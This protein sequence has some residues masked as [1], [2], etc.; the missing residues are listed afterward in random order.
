MDRASTFGTAR[1]TRVVIQKAG[2]CTGLCG[3]KWEYTF[4]TLQAGAVLFDHE[5]LAKAEGALNKGQK[6]EQPIPYAITSHL[7][8]LPCPII[9]FRATRPRSEGHYIFFERPRKSAEP[10]QKAPAPTCFFFIEFLGVSQQVEFRKKSPC[11]NSLQ[12]IEKNS[13]SFPP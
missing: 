5:L 12:K 7:P 2:I 1:L 3:E 13:M 8:H 4:L 6:I 10:I 11:R 9:G